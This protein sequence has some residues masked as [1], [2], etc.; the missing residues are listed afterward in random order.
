MLKCMP[1]VERKVSSSTSTRAVVQRGQGKIEILACERGKGKRGKG[2][3]GE[4]KRNPPQESKDQ[5]KMFIEKALDYKQ[6]FLPGNLR[7]LHKIHD[8]MCPQPMHSTK[9]CKETNGLQWLNRFDSNT[10]APFYPFL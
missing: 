10:R 6:G 8:S 3:K 5:Y 2:G 9:T 4:G 1:I 7:C